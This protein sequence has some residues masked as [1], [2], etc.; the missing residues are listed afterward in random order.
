MRLR[1]AAASGALAGALLASMPARAQYVD[2]R[3]SIGVSGSYNQSISDSPYPTAQTTYAGPAI[4][5]S[6]TL[7][8]V[9]D[10]PRTD[11]TLTYAFTLTA[12]LSEKLAAAT[13]PLTYSNRVTYTGRFA[14][15]ELTTMQLSAGLTQS[16]ISGLSTASSPTETPV[17]TAPTAGLS[18]LQIIAN[19]GISR[20]L[21]D[22]W[23]FTQALAGGFGYP[24]DPTTIRAR[25]ATIGNTFGILHSFDAVSLGLTLSN[26]LTYTSPSEGA[27]GLVTPETLEI[28][29]RLEGNW[30][31]P[32]TP[33]L[34]LAITAGATQ[35]VSPR[36]QEKQM[37]QPSGSATLNYGLDPISASLSYVHTAMPNLATGQTNFMDTG[38]LRFA[39]PFAARTGLG[40]QGSLGYTRSI[41][42]G[43]DGTPQPATHVFIADTALSWAP[44]FTNVLSASLRGQLQRQLPTTDLTTGFLRYS[45]TLTLTYSY[46]SNTAAP[47][48]PRLSPVQSVQAPTPAEINTSDRLYTDGFNGPPAA[49]VGPQKP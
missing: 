12:P 11:N 5:F 8:G 14:L 4:G 21:P 33:T 30:I 47:V 3:A 46:P 40:T 32:L 34:G 24:I 9:L 6:P 28:T 45:I 23:T 41:P 10:T 1:R 2:W 19:E 35:V 43:G 20:Q 29:N 31:Q 37:V 48:R 27:K 26:Q 38:S 39:V 44:P 17:E 16:P 42:I 7:V 22:S 36:A 25:T 49:D 18:M 13:M 15:S